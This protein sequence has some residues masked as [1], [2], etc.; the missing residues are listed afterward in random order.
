MSNQ[1]HTK[2]ASPI[3]EWFKYHFIEKKLSSWPGILILFILALII[4]YFS[5]EV[6]YRAGFGVVLVFAFFF[7]VTLFMKNPYFGLYFL[8]AY[9]ALPNFFIKMLIDSPTKIDF[10]RVIDV[11]T[12]LVFISLFGKAKP[13]KIDKA[14]FWGNP[15]TYAFLLLLFYYVLEALNPNMFSI[16]GWFSFM[17]QYTLVLLSFYILFNL[18]NSWKKVKYFIHF[19]IVLFTVLSAYSCKQQ[20]FGLTSFEQR[21]ATHSLE[22]YLLLFQGGFLRKWSTLSDPAIA[23]VVFSS[24]AVLCAVLLLRVKGTSAK[25]GLSVALMFNLL[26][27]TYSGTRTGTLILVGGIAFYG[28]ATIFELR[29]LIFLAATVGAFI[30]L[31]VSPYSP[32]SISRIKSSFEGTK[33][34]SAAIRD[35]NRHQVQPYLYSHPMGGGVYTSGFEGPKYNPGHFLRDFQPDSGYMKVFAEQGWVGLATL[36]ITYF[37]ILSHALRN[38]YKSL[39]PEFQDYSIALISMIFAL[40]VGQYSQ[41][42]MGAYPQEL[43]YLGALVFFI[44]MPYFENEKINL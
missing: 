21:W 44:K 22:T 23:G 19:N 28:I 1:S 33:D 43:F 2:S 34:P 42:A 18:L 9:S 15:I 36:L 17:S 38:F 37:M 6:D 16:A 7:L 12:L 13:Q 26:G 25:I 29:T 3:G 20:W 24:V 32:P 41:F 5:I 11:L 10:G 35:Y 39:N 30:V 31:M 4:G 14:S 40:M 27:Y 8:I